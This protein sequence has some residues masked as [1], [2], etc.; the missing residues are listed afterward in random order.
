MFGFQGGTAPLPAASPTL[1]QPFYRGVNGAVAGDTTALD[2]NYKP[3]RTDDIDLTIQREIATKMTVEAGYT[4]RILRNEYQEINLDAVPYMTTLGGESFA[5]AYANTYMSLYNLGTGLATGT[6]AANVPVQ[7]FFEAA[8][9][10]AGSAFC[11]AYSS[12]TAAVAAQYAT[13]FQ[14]TRVAD[15]WHSLNNASSWI[16]GRTVLSSPINGNA[17]QATPMSMVT[18]LGYGNYNAL[19]VTCRARDWHGLTAISNFTWG[20]ALRTAP[21]AQYNSSNTALNAY[22]IAAN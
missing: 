18:S 7:P 12:C 13:Y 4:G 10:G 3:E 17:Y 1:P 11:K 6:T 19:F 20:R 16:L 14:N 9:G 5:Q 15:L 2:P 22:S 8:L 21:L